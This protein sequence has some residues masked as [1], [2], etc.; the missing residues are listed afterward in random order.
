MDDNSIKKLVAIPFEQLNTMQ[1]TFQQPQPNYSNLMVQPELKYLS[2]LDDNLKNVLFDSNL[3]PDIKFNKYV[4]LL[5]QY[6]NVRS[7][8]KNTPIEVKLQNAP[9]IQ[10]PNV[11]TTHTN[12]EEQR[13]SSISDQDSV[14][15]QILES[16]PQ[17]QRE[18]GKVLMEAI[19]KHPLIEWDKNDNSIKLRGKVIENSNMERIVNDFMRPRKNTGAGFEE[20]GELLINQNFPKNY[21][22]NQEAW[23]ALLWKR[24]REKNPRRNLFNEYDD[25]DESFLNSTPFS[26]AKSRNQPSTARSREFYSGNQNYRQQN[27]GNR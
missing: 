25:H 23:N 1:T 27:W 26:S 4:E 18:K 12:A 14:K 19:E 22:T 5:N 20:I 8:I 17:K 2:S 7:N 6:S 9:K 15:K 21:I 3:P 10:Q 13:Q 16:L 11:D 24:S